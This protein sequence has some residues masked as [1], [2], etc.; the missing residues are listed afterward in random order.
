MTDDPRE[1]STRAEQRARCVQ[2]EAVEQA[3]SQLAASGELT[4]ER[5]QAVAALALRLRR[6]LVDGP[7]TVA[8]GRSCHAADAD[9]DPTVV[10]ALF[11]D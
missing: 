2:R 1:P 4:E 3:C 7:L 9:V 6:R 5:R 11:T 8:R 10:A